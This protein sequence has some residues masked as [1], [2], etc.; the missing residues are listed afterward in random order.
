VLGAVDSVVDDCLLY[1]AASRNKALKQDKTGLYG[2]VSRAAIR[3]N[4]LEDA[5]TRWGNRLRRILAC[6]CRGMVDLYAPSVILSM[7]LLFARRCLLLLLQF[8]VVTHGGKIAGSINDPTFDTKR[9]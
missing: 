6:V 4:T 2:R 1:E 9:P 7:R 5:G 8:M 3:S